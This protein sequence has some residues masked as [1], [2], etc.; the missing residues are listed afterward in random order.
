VIE[1]PGNTARSSSTAETP[2]AQARGHGREQ[3]VHVLE[4]RVLGERPDLHGPD[5]G[6]LAEIV[7]QQVDDHREF[8]LVLLAGQQLGEQARVFGRVAAA[9]PRALDRPRADLRPIAP[10]EL[11]G[12]AAE[13]RRASPVLDVDG[14]GRG[15]LSHSR[16]N[17]LRG[18]PCQL[19][20]NGCVRL[21][22]KMSPARMCST[23]AA[24][25]R[26]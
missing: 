6:D 15:T 3:V 12:R 25:R 9:R 19:A 5:R 22:W 14:E 4:R 26:S 10:Q 16:Q 20:V 8:G 13:H 17:R 1:P 23:T 7:A 11:L 24:T 18:S 2:P 21:A